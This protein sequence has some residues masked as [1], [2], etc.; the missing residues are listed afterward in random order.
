MIKLPIAM[1]IMSIA[2]SPKLVPKLYLGT[3]TVHKTDTNF[4]NNDYCMI[5][6]IWEYQIIL[7]QN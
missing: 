2:I 6:Y 3:Q 5:S 7:I 4:K 1:Y